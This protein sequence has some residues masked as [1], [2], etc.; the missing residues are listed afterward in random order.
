MINGDQNAMTQNCSKVKEHFQF[1]TIR[2][3]EEYTEA[4]TG[5]HCTLSSHNYIIAQFLVRL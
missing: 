1:T 3:G 5:K 4:N 2:A